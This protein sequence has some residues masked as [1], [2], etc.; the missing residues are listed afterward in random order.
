M[1]K[2]KSNKT[3]HCNISSFTSSTSTETDS[4]GSKSSKYHK[5]EIFFD[6]QD[7][8]IASLCFV[9]TLVAYMKTIHPSLPGGDSGELI[10]AAHEFGVG[11]PPG[12]PLFTLLARLSLLAAPPAALRVNTLSALCGALAAAA[13]CLATRRLCA[14]LPV[15]PQT[16]GG[17]DGAPQTRGGCGGAVLAGLMFPLSRLAWSWALCA[18]VFSLNSLLLAA[19]LATAAVFD[20]CPRHQLAQTSCVGALLCGLCLSNQHTSVLYILVLVPW[21]LHTLY[22]RQVLSVRVC[23][24]VCVWFIAGLLPYV[25]L[26]LSCLRHTARWTWGD[27]SSLG[28]M[29]THLLRQEYGTLD[30]LKDHTGQGFISGLWAY[31]IHAWNDLTPIVCCLFAASLIKTIYRLVHRSS[32]GLEGQ[33]GHPQPAVL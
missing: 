7:I 4:G 17:S 21:V 31:M 16:G 10:T 2:S 22:T 8:L 33:P 18:E 29:M 23:V 30:L 19:L 6:Q 11:H 9:I 27:Q 32:G 26:P 5:D 13:T 20:C 28:G 1:G 12:Y 14:S 3:K 24:R 25:Y 15:V